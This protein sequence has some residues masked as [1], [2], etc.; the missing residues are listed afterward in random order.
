MV[1]F[2]TPSQPAAWWKL[3]VDNGGGSNF[4]PQIGIWALAEYIELPRVPVTPHD[5][6]HIRDHSNIVTGGQGHRLGVT[7]DYSQRTFTYRSQL[8]TQAFITNTWIPF[9]ESYRQSNFA[10]MWNYD[11]KP[12]EA[13]LMGFTRPNHTMPYS[14]KWRRLNFE[15]SGRYVE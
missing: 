12:N 15:M 5:P 13:Y 6:D 4:I 7:N 14:S 11:D 10:W 8:I 3:T 2:F 1:K 9:L